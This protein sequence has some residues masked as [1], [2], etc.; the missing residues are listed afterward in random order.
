M[1]LVRSRPPKIPCSHVLLPWLYTLCKPAH[2]KRHTP[3]HPSHTYPQLVFS[4]ELPLDTWNLASR[5]GRGMSPVC[6]ALAWRCRRRNTCP[7]CL[8]HGW[9]SSS[10]DGDLRCTSHPNVTLCPLFTFHS[11]CFHISRFTF[12]MSHCT[13]HI[14]RCIRH[15]SHST[16]HVSH[17][18]V[19]HFTFHISLFH[20]AHS[21]LHV[22]FFTCHI[23]RC[24]FDIARCTF[25]ISHCTMHVSHFTL[26]IAHVTFH[27][28]RGMLHL[29]NCT[30]HVAYATLIRCTTPPCRGVVPLTRG[31][32]LTWPI[33]LAFKGGGPLLWPTLLPLGDGPPPLLPSRAPPA[34]WTLLL[35]R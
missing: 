15:S 30:L 16:S 22:A 4:Q 28:A 12:P 2:L 1:H 11:A 20:V 13:L 31:G 19:S 9:Y 21:T 5:L 10:H 26:H 14:A 32:P 6:R 24:T 17:L 35:L 27:I 18:Y 29:W 23:A 34:P 8:S 7:P 33:L 25:H 3:T